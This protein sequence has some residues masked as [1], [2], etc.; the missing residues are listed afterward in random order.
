MSPV[1]P[2]EQ[3]KQSFNFRCTGTILLPHAGCV[4]AVPLGHPLAG[5]GFFDETETYLNPTGDFDFVQTPGKNSELYRA[6]AGNSV[7]Q[8]GDVEQLV[9]F[10]TEVFFVLVGIL[11]RCATN[12]SESLDTPAPPAV[13]PFFSA[14]DCVEP[15][16]GIG[17]DSDQ[18][19]QVGS[20]D[21]PTVNRSEPHMDMDTATLVD[22]MSVRFQSGNHGDNFL[23]SLF[24]LQNRANNFATGI[25]GLIRMQTGIPHGDPAS[26][27]VGNLLAPVVFADFQIVLRLDDCFNFYAKSQVLGDDAVNICG[28][29]C[30]SVHV[31]VLVAP[32]RGE[33]MGGCPFTYVRCSTGV[34]N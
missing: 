2:A 34:N 16:F 9:L 33:V 23:D 8:M 24:P 22:F 1:D 12:D 11:F 7:L 10:P 18:F 29:P 19:A 30:D 14:G 4:L 21:F 26:R 17:A 32:V 20:I 27:Q 5:Q 6:F 28:I 13:L 3:G 31:S 15:L 25:A